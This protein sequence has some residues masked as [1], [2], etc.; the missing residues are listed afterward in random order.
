MGKVIDAMES[1]DPIRQRDEARAIARRLAAL[2]R[3][4]SNY[5]R[6]RP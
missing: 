3:V 5:R 2:T 4:H 6:T 1:I